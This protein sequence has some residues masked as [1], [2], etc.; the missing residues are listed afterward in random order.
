MLLPDMG[1][2]HWLE[3]IHNNWAMS[4]EP[5]LRIFTPVR[6]NRPAQVQKKARVMKLQ[7]RN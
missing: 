1:L 5:V 2:E 3:F 6:L 4:Q 7:Y